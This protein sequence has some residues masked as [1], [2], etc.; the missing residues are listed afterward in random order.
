MTIMESRRESAGWSAPRVASFSGTYRDIDPFITVDG[1]QLFFNSVRPRHE[2]DRR[3][4]FDIW[5]AERAD[6]GW[7]EPVN[8]GAPLNSDSSDIYATAT[9]DGTV[10]FVSR[11]LV[12]RGGNDLYRAAFADGQYLDPENLGAPIN[13][14]YSESN[15]YIAADESYLIFFSD[16]PGGYGRS[17]LY[18]SHRRDGRWT[19]PLNLGPRINTPDAEFCP[20]ISPGGRYFFF[21]RSIF[22]GEQR[23]AENIHYLPVEALPLLSEAQEARRLE[24]AER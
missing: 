11:R 7:G 14:A 21:S 24:R 16:R 10:Y 13:T 15:P 1:R 20:L 17:D 5:V 19:E 9:A 6:G 23:V 3:G 8:P 18:I 4:D 12:G 2:G 22:E